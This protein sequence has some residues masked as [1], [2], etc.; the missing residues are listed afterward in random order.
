MKASIVDTLL[1]SGDAVIQSVPTG[2][3]LFCLG[4][5][6]EHYVIVK[7]GTVRVELLTTTGHQLLLYRIN[8]GESCVMTT[9]CLLSN[10]NYDAQA[11]TESTTELVLIRRAAFKRLTTQ[12]PEF[13][14]FVFNNFSERLAALVKRTT[15]LTTQSVDQRLAAALLARAE[16]SNAESAINLTH[17]Q[18]AVDIGSAR[19]VISRRLSH[20]EKQALIER[21]RGQI[22]IKDPVA[23]NKMLQ[24]V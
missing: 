23:L 2:S 16:Q 19:E 11:L 18:L 9:S 20:F 12:S 24:S 8:A 15:E 13:L 14:E 6:C 10:S 17:Q 1:E 3:Q 22:V 5:S 7:T 21:Q 4:D